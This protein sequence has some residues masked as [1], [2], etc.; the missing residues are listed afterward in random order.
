MIILDTLLSHKNFV[1]TKM[2]K[3]AL[4]VSLLSL[5]AH[6]VSAENEFTF[7]VPVVIQA[8][9]YQSGSV[10]CTVLNNAGTTVGTGVN[11]FTGEAPYRVVTVNVSANQPRDATRYKCF[12]NLTIAEDNV[13][14]GQSGESLFRQRFSTNTGTQLRAATVLVSGTIQ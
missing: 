10:R 14:Y 11:S 13:L 8:L 2:F 12:L 3:K 5:A 9:E 7:N 6:D 4:L 1:F